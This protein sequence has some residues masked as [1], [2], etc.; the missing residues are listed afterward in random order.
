MTFRLVPVAIELA[1]LQL[2][3]LQSFVRDMRRHDALLGACFGVV[4]GEPVL[5]QHGDIRDSSHPWVHQLQRDIQLMWA[6]DE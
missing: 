6:L 5:D 1:I 3:V 2:Q 4:H